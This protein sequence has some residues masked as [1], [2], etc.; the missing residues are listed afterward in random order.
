MR[1]FHEIFAKK[2]H[3]VRN[4]KQKFPENKDFEIM[5]LGPQLDSK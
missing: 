5:N 1:C 3:T 2:A 4:A